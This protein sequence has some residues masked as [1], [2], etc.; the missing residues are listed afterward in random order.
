MS[1]KLNKN[2]I[3]LMQEAHL[4]AEELSRRVGLPA[5]TI[6]KIRNNSDPNPTLSTLIPLAKYFSLSISQLV[7]DEP[8]PASRIKGSYSINSEALHHVPLISWQEAILWPN[9]PNDSSRPT[10]T[11]EHHYSKH[12]YALLVEED[13]W[14]N[15]AKDTALLVDPVLAV[16]HRDYIIIYKKGQILPSLKQALYDEGQMYLKPVTLGYNIALL[17]QEHEILG[18]VVEYKKHLKQHALVQK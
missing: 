15:L 13:N 9:I 14:E 4:N 1:E 18:V 17:T 7:G 2:L 11:T 16:D 10:I 6:K 12:A 8:I 5:S 3:L